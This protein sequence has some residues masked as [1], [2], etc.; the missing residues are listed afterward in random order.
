MHSSIQEWCGGGWHC[1]PSLP[2]HATPMWYSLK[3]CGHTQQNHPLS[4]PAPCYF[5]LIP[6][7]I[8][9]F[10]AVPP[11]PTKQTRCFSSAHMVLQQ[12]NE[13][14]EWR[15]LKYDA[16]HISYQISN[17]SYVSRYVC[18]HFLCS[19]SYCF[20]SSCQYSSYYFCSRSR[21]RAEKVD[22]CM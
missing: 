17:W 5:N 6:K 21:R 14:S 2:P 10:P 19:M 22:K 20:F 12:S 3:R 11:P 9:E 1:T 4:L 7:L 8:I 16:D 18:L 15:F 13:V